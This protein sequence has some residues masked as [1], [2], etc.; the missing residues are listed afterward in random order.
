MQKNI[1][2]A[3]SFAVAILAGGLIA[4]VVTRPAPGPGEAEIR[5]M[6]AEAV[7]EQTT[8]A[9]TEILDTGDL[10]PL[11]EMYLMDNPRLLQRMTA[12]LQQE[13]RAEEIA[14]NRAALASMRDEIFDD[15]GNIVLG[16]P[17][18]DVTLVE[19]F[20]YNCGYCRQMVAD[21]LAL[22]END[23]DLRVILREFPV[24][25]EGSYAAASVGLLVNQSGQV[26]YRDYHQALF[27]ARGA[28]DAEMALSTAEDLGLDRAALETGMNSDEVSAAIRRT[29]N[30][31]QALG[32]A[33]TPA[34]IIGDEIIPGAVPISEITSR[35][36]NMRECGAT[37]C[38]ELDG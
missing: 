14:R 35:I 29:Y 22:I 3:L 33:G 36:A 9:E 34:F 31:A 5:A 13:L 28:I 16:N 4:A 2:L 38:A 18:G 19:M 21:I 30:V 27:S 15:P 11:I 10:G 20:D 17:E 7:G 1:N 6:I 25:S 26:D 24:L 23:P 32:I 8:P 12:A 37:V